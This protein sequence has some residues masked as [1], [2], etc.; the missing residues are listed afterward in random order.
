[1][2]V[3][4][5]RRVAS[6]LDL[7]RV[8]QAP[9]KHRSHRRP[10]RSE[11]REQPV[12]SKRRRRRRLPRSAVRPRRAVGHA[13]CPPSRSAHTCAGIRRV[14]CPAGRCA[15]TLPAQFLPSSKA[16]AAGARTRSLIH[17]SR[18]GNVVQPPHV[19]Q[20]HTQRCLTLRS[21]GPAPARHLGREAVHAYHP[22]R[23]QGASPT[24][25]AQLKR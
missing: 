21:S 12:P 15:R 16:A 17:A 1:M 6:S 18:S 7:S 13:S 2:R 25:A 5:R 4:H 20:W 23:G 24:R 3:V 11:G 9:S 22:P 14:R 8:F 10:S 19:A